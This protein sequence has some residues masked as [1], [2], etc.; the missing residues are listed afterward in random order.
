[1]KEHSRFRTLVFLKEHSE[2]E[3][4]YVALLQGPGGLSLAT[5]RDARPVHV[6]FVVDEKCRDG[7]L[8]DVFDFPF[9]LPFHKCSILISALYFW[10]V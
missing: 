3:G 2:N 5:H 4:Q 9:T 8:S 1:M 7:F 10:L 6:R